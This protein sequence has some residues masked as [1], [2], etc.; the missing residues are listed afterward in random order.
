LFIPV[1]PAFGKLRQEDCGFEASLN[2]IMRPCLRKTKYKTTKR[3]E[4]IV[5]M[6]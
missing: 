2:Y 6:R 5:T 3:N 1:I 4:G